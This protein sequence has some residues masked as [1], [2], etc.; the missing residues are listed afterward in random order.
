MAKIPANGLIKHAFSGVAASQAA[1]VNPTADALTDSTT[2]SAGTTLAAGVGRYNLTFQFD[3][4][5]IADGDLVTDLLLNH[6]FK[7]IE[8]YWVTTEPV[9]T[10]A[11]A[12]TL[13][14]DIGTTAV[15]NSNIALTSANC[16]PAGV[17]VQNAGALA[18]NTGSATDVITVKAASTTAFS[19]GKGVLVI[20]IQNMDDADAF[21]TLTAQQ[22]KSIVDDAAI[23]SSLQ[24]SGL[25]DS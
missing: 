20:C 22:A 18:A 15:T 25:M 8:S 16:T 5:D 12:S 19:E 9:T 11:K 17:K 21:A 23:I 13:S 2:G 6:K 14:L 7:I 1:D 3:L 4:A 10:A 24:T